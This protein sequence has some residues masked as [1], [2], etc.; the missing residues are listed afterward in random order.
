MLPVQDLTGCASTLIG[1][2]ARGIK[3]ISGGERRRLSVG[4]G[5]VTNPRSALSGM[6]VL[7]ASA[8]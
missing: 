2:D 3:G 5:L 7:C 1:D 4:I 6:L 8:P